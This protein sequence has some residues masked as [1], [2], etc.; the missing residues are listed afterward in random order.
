MDECW[1]WNNLSS[2]RE[3]KFFVE[4]DEATGLNLSSG[5]REEFGR[6]SANEAYHEVSLPLEHVVDLLLF[7]G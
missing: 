2:P 3:L 1:V 4:V 6:P 5:P 7:C